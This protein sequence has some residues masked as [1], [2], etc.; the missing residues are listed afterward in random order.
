[1]LCTK[2]IGGGGVVL[3]SQAGGKEFIVRANQH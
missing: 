1:V 3:R 2:A